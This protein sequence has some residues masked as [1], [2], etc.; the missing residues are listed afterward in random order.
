MNNALK[1]IAVII[2]LLLANATSHAQ[3]FKAKV[4]MGKDHYVLLRPGTDTIHCKINELAFGDAGLT[5]LR[6]TTKG[7][8]K[9][10]T[11]KE[12]QNVVG[13]RM[14]SFAQ[15]LASVPDASNL[16]EER[17]MQ[18]LNTG[19]VRLLT[20]VQ[21]TL[22]EAQEEEVEVSFKMFYWRVGDLVL[23]ITASL[24]EEVVVPSLNGCAGLELVGWGTADDKDYLLELTKYWNAHYDCITLI[25]LN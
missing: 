6:I 15:E 7:K 9:S 10:F 17:W 19:E 21:N 25:D 11:K 20:G 13:Y 8:S 22:L 5:K 4:N 3:S 23:P 24:L 12:L 1:S 14:G 18:V 16:K 2:L